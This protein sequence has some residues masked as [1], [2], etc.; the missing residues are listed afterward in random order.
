MKLRALLLLTAAV[1]AVSAPAI[2]APKPKPA[3]AAAPEAPEVTATKLRDAALKSNVAYDFVAELTTRFGARPAGS[4]SE[5]K[6]AEWSAAELKKMG[7]DNVRIESFPLQIWQRGAENLEIVGPF[8]QKMVVTALGGSGATP[9]G[10]V[11]GEAAIFETYAEFAD[12]KADLTGKI[13][14]ILQPTVR[15]QTGQG[16]GVNSGSVR[17]QGP[18]LARSRG[19]VGYIMRSLGTED[20]R[21]AH[22]GATRFLGEQGLAALAMSP[23]DA[24]QFERLL[25]LQREGKAGPIRLKML[26]TPTFKGAGM[27]QNVVA[28]IKGSKRPN[29]V[30]VIGG[31]LDSWDLGTGAI[32]DGAGVAITMAAA[33]V[34]LDQGVRP[35]RTVRVVFWGS[36]EVSQPGDQGLSGANAYATAH[37]GDTHIAAAESDFGADVIYSLQLPNSNYPDFNKRLGIVLYPLNIFIDRVVSTGGG[38]DT[39]PLNAK[40]VPVFDLQ[41]NGTDYFDVH[42]TAD[43]TLDRID[44][45]KMTQ[46]VAAW[47]ATVWMIA[48]TE[49]VFQPTN[50]K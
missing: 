13:V 26:S 31:H 17:R 10:G 20:H 50:G 45:K 30:I 18:E 40:G 41:Q 48:N 27:S 35:E 39:S 32:D 47:A 14:V 6:A 24:E 37:A 38:P 25:R 9:A 15:T 4:E 43:D 36:E 23:P 11:E 1:L 42:H 19:A 49:V 21:F 12:S 8:A 3:P 2:A 16:Y 33:K 34:I 44:P 28:E 29:E 5:R 7:F 46:N 22:T